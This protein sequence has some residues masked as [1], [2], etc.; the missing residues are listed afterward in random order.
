MVPEKY[1]LASI[2]RYLIEA[3]ERRRPA[4]RAWTPEVEATLRADCEQELLQMER[5]LKELEIDD[6][7]Y[8][9]R[10]RELVDDVLIPRY[11]KLAADEIALANKE[12]G[13]WR[14]GDLIARATF[15]AAGLALGI[16]AVELPYIP[17]YEKW[18][19]AVLLVAGPWF[20]DIALWWYRRRYQKKLNGLI[21]DLAKANRSIDTYRPLSEISRSMGA[22]VEPLRADLAEAPPTPGRS[23][24]DIGKNQAPGTRDPNE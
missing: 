19:P 18:F 14:G 22:T 12:Y 8:W 1:S 21:A 5:Q 11:A 13:I 10:A 3:F 23:Q 2:G 7:A 20:P 15:A 6:P 9:H 16:V 4:L 24:S 17:V